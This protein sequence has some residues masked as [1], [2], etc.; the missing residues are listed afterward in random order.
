MEK[1]K[2][3]DIR[4]EINSFDRELAALLEKRME[5]VNLVAEHKRKNGVE[6]LDRNREQKVIENVMSA[7]V[8]KD[9]ADTVRASFESIMEHSRE[10]QK[11]RLQ[12]ARSMPKERKFA[13]IGEHLS[14]SM[15]VSIHNLFFKY[16]GLAGSYELM[17]VPRNKLSGILDKL[18]S[19]G[20][21]GV[22][23]TIPYKSEIMSFLDSLSNDAVRVGAVNTIKIGD[24]FTGH[25]TDY[26][27][28]GMALSH[29][30]F[31]PDGKKCAVLGSGGACRAV[32]A[33]LEDHGAKSISIVTRDTD[34]AVIKF[35]GLIT[36]ESENFIARDIDLIINATPVGMSPNPGFSPVSKSRLEGAGFVMDLIYNPSETLLLKYAAE[37][38]IPCANGLY[39]LAAQGV[40]AEEI[41]QDKLFDPELINK[42]YEDLRLL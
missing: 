14:H 19:K 35:P 26:S 38:G 31:D 6:V 20:F 25:N 39:M 34:A 15:S 2:L 5:L 29:Y 1:N 3:E 24:K 4:K 40:S 21:S 11:K 42:I 37:L 22:N 28:F 32:V 10:F 36:V 18:R 27:G 8:N 16:A 9:Y 41:W 7:V 23:V 30:G 12:N 17:E 33:Y 13:L